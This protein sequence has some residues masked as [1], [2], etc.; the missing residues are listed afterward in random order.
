[1]NTLGRTG[2]TNHEE[3]STPEVSQ[4]GRMVTSDAVF[5]TLKV[6]KESSVGPSRFSG[7]PRCHEH[8]SDLF[9]EG[10]RTVEARAASSKLASAVFKPAPPN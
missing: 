10:A 9:A 8:D 5:E 2:T 4:P 7:R 1:M 3:R 6:C